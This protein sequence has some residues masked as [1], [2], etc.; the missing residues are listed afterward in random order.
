M[1]GLIFGIRISMI[2]FFLTHSLGVF[3]QEDSTS[4]GYKE[5]EQAVK[6]N[7][8]VPRLIYFIHSG[9]SVMQLFNVSVKKDDEN[10]VLKGWTTDI[11]ENA[12]LV[13][14]KMRE[15]ISAKELT[16]EEKLLANQA[17]IEVKEINTDSGSVTILLNFAQSYTLWLGNQK[18]RR[19][20][21]WII[22]V[23]GGTAAV[24]LIG[25]VTWFVSNLVFY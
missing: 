9:D 20:N 8:K 24:G 15:G 23:I 6:H 17:H 13:Y 25:F 10:V 2:L 12:L 19:N 7:E 3:A 11:D 21:K 14:K 16:A 1:N 18:G 4:I 5:A 22:P